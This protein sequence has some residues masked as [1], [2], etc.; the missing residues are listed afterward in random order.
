[1]LFST[2]LSHSDLPY[3]P[4]DQKA[5]KHYCFGTYIYTDG[6]IY[7]GEW[8]DD[9]FYVRGAIT[10]FDGTKYECVFKDGLEGLFNGQGNWIKTD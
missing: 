4:K 5:H 8:R 3:C 9:K 6:L 1:M 7:F 2:V 10:F